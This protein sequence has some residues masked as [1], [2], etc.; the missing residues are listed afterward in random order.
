M[1]KIGEGIDLQ[2][3]IIALMR[4]LEPTMSDT[5]HLPKSEMDNAAKTSQQ[6]NNDYQS[7]TPDFATNQT[8]SS[9]APSLSSPPNILLL[10]R[11]IGNQAVRRLLQGNTPSPKRMA[12]KASSSMPASIQRDYERPGLHGGVYESET[13]G[14][15]SSKRE[16]PTYVEIPVKATSTSD[17]AAAPPPLSQYTHGGKVEGSAAERKAGFDGGHII[18]LHIGGEDMPE[19]VVPMFK[20]FNR[21]VYKKME[22]TIKKKAG[23]IQKSGKKPWITVHCYYGDAL[24]DT[25]Y[26]FDV[27]L[28]STPADS[29]ERTAVYSEFL[30]Q[31][32]DIK[33]VAPLK[34]DEQKIVRGEVKA[35]EVRGTAGKVL[36]ASS[37]FFD[38]GDSES[39]E[40][41]INTHKHLP[42]TKKGMYPD[43]V[44]L[45]PYE[46]LDMLAFAN[47]LDAGTE[48]N[49]FREFTGRQRELILQANMARN[50]GVLKS[51][52]P[53]DTVNDGVLSEQ[54]DLNFPEI[55][56]I[57]PKSK[58]GS[59]FFSNARVV[60]WQMNN[61][62]DRVKSLVGIVDISKRA[63]PPLQGM[64]AKDIPVLVEQYCA[65]NDISVLF[66]EQDVWNWGAKTFTIMSG[67]SAT[68]RRLSIVK[69][70]L[71]K[72]VLSGVLIQKEG[73]FQKKT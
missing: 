58:G 9:S 47:Q 14:G 31:P 65:R 8:A 20:A 62:D 19:N 49:A 27:L 28:E 63:L 66:S 36:N 61:K 40:A 1:V 17:R 45:R 11:V 7:L 46:F 10:Q 33:L 13:F 16:R 22:D 37:D 3:D 44:S 42:P 51:D 30:R 73:K 53:M 32:E 68:N 12:V 69:T 18:G 29:H 56:H 70:A 26:A 59:N 15:D 39:V 38:L 50:G 71:L 24:T 34:E 35:D 6:A 60:S 25:P 54:G 4:W 55:D 5:P 41:Y 23:E 52:D 67:V 48:L 57:V 43:P 21:G 72:Y 2:F 64:G